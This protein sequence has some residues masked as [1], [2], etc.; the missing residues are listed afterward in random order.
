M[1]LPT[2]F[3][4]KRK[5]AGCDTNLCTITM[6][7]TICMS[8]EQ[9]LKRSSKNEPFIWAMFLMSYSYYTPTSFKLFKFRLF[10]GYSESKY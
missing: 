6:L 2:H 3:L 1:T 7:S 10:R 5:L 9:F 4:I 8:H